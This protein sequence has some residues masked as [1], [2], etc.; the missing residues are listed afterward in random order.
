MGAKKTYIKLLVIIVNK[1]GEKEGGTSVVQSIHH[2]HELSEELH[3]V[4]RTVG[5][6]GMSEMFTYN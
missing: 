4:V 3:I 1:D 5:K 2:Q 6:N